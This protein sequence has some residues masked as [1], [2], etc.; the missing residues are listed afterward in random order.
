MSMEGQVTQ[1]A[2]APLMVAATEVE[3]QV[4]YEIIDAETISL[5]DLG[6]RRGGRNGGTAKYPIEKL[7]V[8]QS[9]FV[10]ATEA[11]KDPLKTLGSA[12]S[13]A[14]MKFATQTGKETKTLPKRGERNRLVLDEKGERIMEVREVATYDFAR[15]YTLRG[16]TS[17]QIVGK[18][19]APSKG[20]LVRRIK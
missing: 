20:V 11:L 17:G 4:S 5:A 1:A 8:G 16:V 18:W 10:P 13:A 6:K 3:A 14:K 15:Q 9:F 7:T 19:R 2:A 12:V